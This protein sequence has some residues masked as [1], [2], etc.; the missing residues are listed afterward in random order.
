MMR[1]IRSDGAAYQ[2]FLQLKRSLSRSSFIFKKILI[3]PFLEILEIAM[4]SVEK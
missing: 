1:G 2:E 3:T 4:A